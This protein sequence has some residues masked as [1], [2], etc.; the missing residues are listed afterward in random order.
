MFKNYLQPIIH[1][2]DLNQFIWWMLFFSGAIFFVYYNKNTTN[3]VQEYLTGFFGSTLII[4]SIWTVYV[5]IRKQSLS[6]IAIELYW[7]VHA[8]NLCLGA[9]ALSYDYYYF[10]ASH[11][12]AK[13]IVYIAITQGVFWIIYLTIA[14]CLALLKYKPFEVKHRLPYNVKVKYFIMGIFIALAIMGGGYL[15]VDFVKV[16][17]FAGISEIETS[18]DL[19]LV[20]IF[21]QLFG[22]HFYQKVYYMNKFKEHVGDQPESM[23]KFISEKV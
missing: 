20:A 9:F 3:T 8:T 14:G 2:K 7:A 18:I 19:F 5:A 13:S 23:F 6:Y 21:T 10:A 1:K 22:L 12:G 17:V 4:L 11:P 15:L 16:K